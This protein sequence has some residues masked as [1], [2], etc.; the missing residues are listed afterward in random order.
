[1]AYPT[2]KEHDEYQRYVIEVASNGE[3]PLS[4]EEWRKQKQSSNAGGDQKVMTAM[5][6]Y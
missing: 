1:M 5:S 2:E 4:K 3:K 6:K